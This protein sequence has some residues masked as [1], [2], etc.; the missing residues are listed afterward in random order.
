MKKIELLAFLVDNDYEWPERL[1]E[2]YRLV[3]ERKKPKIEEE[4]ERN[5]TK[6][7]QFKQELSSYVRGKFT[8]A[9]ACEPSYLK[10]WRR[11]RNT[12][13]RVMIAMLSLM[14]G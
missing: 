8:D 7:K 2:D 9:P 14:C 13:S 4:V 11:G 10:L 5:E 6:L 12:K 1:R 3:T